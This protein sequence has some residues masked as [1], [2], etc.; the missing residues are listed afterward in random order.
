MMCRSVKMLAATAVAVV[1]LA[2]GAWAQEGPTLIPA[3]VMFDPTGGTVSPTEATT[4]DGKLASLPTPERPGY[5]FFGW[6]TAATGGNE[7]TTST[8]FGAGSGFG[9]PDYILYAQWREEPPPA[10]G[11]PKITFNANGGTVTPTTITIENAYGIIGPLPTPERD[12][13]RFSGWFTAATGGYP[14]TA[15]SKFLSG[16]NAVVYA[17]WTENA[18]GRPV[19]TF[20]PT[21]GT[22]TPTTVTITSAYDI[23]GSLPTPKRTG[24]IFNGWFTTAETGGTLVTG[25][26]VFDNDATIFARWIPAPAVWDVGAET[27]K[28][29]AKL[30][31][32]GTLTISGS[33]A[34][35]DFVKG[36]HL[37]KAAASAADGRTVPWYGDNVKKVVVENGVTSVGENAFD[38]CVNLISV[39]IGKDVASIGAGAFS[40]N[41]ALASI[42][43]MGETPPSIA[44]SA[45]TGVDMASVSLYVPKSADGAYESAGFGNIKGYTSVTVPRVSRAKQFSISQNGSNLRIVG[46]SQATPV[47]I[48]DMRGRLLMSHSA[49]PNEVISVSNLARGTYLVKALGN[50]V[51]IVR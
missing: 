47:R 16:E 22:V 25:N 24:Y 29:T 43:Y 40:G 28:V 39:T 48:Y 33:G 11:Y 50:S 23:L 13:Y 41:S 7:V 32:D 35:A 42:S 34:M 31:E 5:V 8:E 46:T 21:G 14:I 9:V 30:S 6:F 3:R 1:G 26:T 45:F 37:G 2:A 36:A 44:S 17:Q 19:I 18:K 27:G 20:N 49:M 15:E 38:G 4:V 12:G 10:I 51:K